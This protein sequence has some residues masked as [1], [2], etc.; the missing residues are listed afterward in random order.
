MKLT[1]LGTGTSQG[2]PVIG[3]LCEVCRSTDRRDNRLRTSAMV[4]CGDVRLVIDAGPDFRQQMLHQP[5]RRLDGV[6]LTHIHYDHVGGLDDLRPFCTFG[7]IDVYANEATAEALHHTMPYVFAEEKY[8]GVPR[9][10]LHVADPYKPIY[11]GDI[12]VMPFFV[13]HRNSLFTVWA[14]VPADTLLPQRTIYHR[15]S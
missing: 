12:P 7:D 14:R 1:F 5:F 8:P 6:L 13:M 9:I 11:V 10:D 4:E 15:F 2:V 3:C